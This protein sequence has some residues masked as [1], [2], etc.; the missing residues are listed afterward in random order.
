MGIVFEP[1]PQTKSRSK[2][3]I[4]GK[5]SPD[6]ETGA[7]I[8]HLSIRGAAIKTGQLRVGDELISIDD[9]FTSQLPFDDIMSIFI[10]SKR[11]FSLL[12]RA[13]KESPLMSII[14]I[15]SQTMKENEN[16]SI[17]PEQKLKLKRKNSKI[18][19]ESK[20][21]ENLAMAL[22]NKVVMNAKKHEKGNRRGKHFSQEE[23]SRDHGDENKPP[24]I[25]RGFVEMFFD[26]LCAPCGLKEAGNAYQVGRMEKKDGY[27][28][29][30]DLS[31]TLIR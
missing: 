8:K 28:Y 31:S 2:S 14:V 3:T 19:K 29:P 5:Q 30:R 17:S 27:L 11:S 22:R 16:K 4:N 7:R 23:K 25:D 24:P 6:D 13:R 12:F 1:I 10:R 21:D 18:L 9:E 20:Y 26:T 15:P